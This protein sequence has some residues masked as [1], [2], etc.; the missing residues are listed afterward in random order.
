MAKPKSGL[1][2][3][4]GS[5]LYESNTEI[6]EKSS[7]STLRISDVQPRSSQPRKDFDRASLESLADSISKHGLIQPIIV[8][9]GSA[10][11]YEI[12]AGERRWRASK[13]AGLTEV[14]VIVLDADDKKT[15]ELSLIENIQREDLNPIEEALAY[16]ALI[17]EFGLTQEELAERVCKSRPAVANTLLL[18]DL[19]DEIIAM[20]ASKKLTEGHARAL[21]AIKDRDKMLIAAGIVAE[22]QLSVRDAEALARRLNAERDADNSPEAPKKS[23]A[24]SIDYRAALEKKMQMKLG[25]RVAIK[26]KGRVKKLELEF[27]DNSDLE[28]LA[29]L[30][31]GKTIFDD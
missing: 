10:G 21:R 11:Y 31:C 18:L 14:P 17:D 2:R 15:A 26:D 19:P 23:L 22:K 13:M 30:L 24:E 28:A 25:R 29:E 7:A 8:R 6:K 27:V 3:G 5:L 20:V 4:L 12:I 9:K 1:G 16:R